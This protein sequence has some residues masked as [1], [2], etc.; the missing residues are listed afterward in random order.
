MEEIPKIQTFQ[1]AGVMEVNNAN[2]LICN[3]FT[4]LRK[5]GKTSLCKLQTL[6]VLP[7]LIDMT[8]TDGRMI[9][10]VTPE[11]K[12]IIDRFSRIYPN[13]G[14]DSTL[15]IETQEGGDCYE[16]VPECADLISEFTFNS[17]FN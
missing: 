10:W 1:T 6:T 16:E 4:Y 3:Y 5:T 13:V 7:L 11:D 17:I 8:T 2:T 15:Q 9:S 12:K 14:F